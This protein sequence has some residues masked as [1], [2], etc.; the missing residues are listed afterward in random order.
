MISGQPLAD[1]RVQAFLDTKEVVVLAMVGAHGAP[2]ATPMWFLHAPESLVMISVEDTPKIPLLRRDPR[3]T[4]VAETT[5]PEG[6]IGGVVVNGRAEFLA[7]SAERRS[8]AERFLAKYHP[9]LERLW[10]GRAMPSNRV[11][12]R[13]VPLRVRTW[14]L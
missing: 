11:M 13:I 2:A 5:T 4:V 12:F 9:R 7:D 8:L 6:A 1:P 3:V 10:A 14:G